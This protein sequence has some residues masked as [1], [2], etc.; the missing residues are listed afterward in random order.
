MVETENKSDFKLLGV[1]AQRVIKHEQ[2][3]QIVAICHCLQQNMIFRVEHNAWTA[4]I[5]M[6]IEV[7]RNTR[8]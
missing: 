1:K 5:N 7:K 2:Q 3:E 6:A 4:S 8:E